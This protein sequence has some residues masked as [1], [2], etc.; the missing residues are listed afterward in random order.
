MAVTGGLNFFLKNKILGFWFH[1]CKVFFLENIR[2]TL[3][4]ETYK[5]QQSWGKKKKVKQKPKLKEE[6][7]YL[8]TVDKGL[9]KQQVLNVIET[10]YPDSQC[11]MG[12]KGRPV[13]WVS[14]PHSLLEYSLSGL[15]CWNTSN[16]YRRK[17]QC[18][19]GRSIPWVISPHVTN[20]S[21]KPYNP[22]AFSSYKM[23]RTEE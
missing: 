19:Q 9:L 2:S 12:S 3:S 17:G 22:E 4:S 7:Q 15:C 20:W 18:V 13:L 5:V 23:N 8:I 6:Y 14:F 10:K 21:L 1:L 16:Q 11:G